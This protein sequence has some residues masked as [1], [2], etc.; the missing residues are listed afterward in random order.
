MR[1]TGHLIGSEGN[2]TRVPIPATAAAAA[3]QRDDRGGGF[4]LFPLGPPVDARSCDELKQHV[5]VSI[6]N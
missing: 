2:C 4:V 1:R 5:N 3:G 6:L